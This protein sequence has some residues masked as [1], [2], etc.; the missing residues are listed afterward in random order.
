VDKI[1]NT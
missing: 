1:V